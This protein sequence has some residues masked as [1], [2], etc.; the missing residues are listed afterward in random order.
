LI[1]SLGI[2]NWPFSAPNMS[3]LLTPWH[4]LR[5]VLCGLVNHRQQQI[6]EFQNAHIEALATPQITAEQTSEISETGGTQKQRG[7]RAKRSK[8]FGCSRLWRVADIRGN[9]GQVTV[10][11]R[12]TNNRDFHS[13]NPMFFSGIHVG[14]HVPIS[15]TTVCPHDPNPSF[16]LPT[17]SASRR[18]HR[19]TTW[20]AIVVDR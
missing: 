8:S 10:A 20:F 7:L 6:I 1:S 3:F 9:R 19:R 2:R 14:F 13:G 15:T 11:Q 4:I 18:Q 16:A 5:A 12:R 17:R